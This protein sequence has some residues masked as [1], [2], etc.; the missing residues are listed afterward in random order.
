MKLSE[1]ER[2][3]NKIKSFVTVQKPTDKPAIKSKCDSLNSHYPLI[4]E[5][6]NLIFIFFFSFEL[7]NVGEN[8][9]IS[10]FLV[11]Y[12]SVN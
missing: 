10:Y 7:F 12:F 8:N 3:K 9:F 5:K 1:N 6:R 2:P 11:E 4:E